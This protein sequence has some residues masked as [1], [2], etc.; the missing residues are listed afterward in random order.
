MTVISEDCD[1]YAMSTLFSNSMTKV[2]HQVDGNVKEVPCPEI[3]DDYIAFMGRVDMTLA[4]K[5]VAGV[6]TS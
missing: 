6:V 3:I 1:I 2:K 4:E 5:L